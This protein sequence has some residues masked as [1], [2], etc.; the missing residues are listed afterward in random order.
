MKISNYDTL[1]HYV[2]TLGFAG[3]GSMLERRKNLSRVC[4]AILNSAGIDKTDLVD[5][6]E[7]D[8]FPFEVQF[9]NFV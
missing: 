3:K 5:V 4:N 6:D 9:H 2:M 8:G 7:P 1:V